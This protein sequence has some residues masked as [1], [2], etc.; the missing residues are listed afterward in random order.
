MKRVF[1]VVV[2]FGGMCLGGC[3]G[4]SADHG[5]SAGAG[6]EETASRYP[7]PSPSTSRRRDRSE[8]RAKGEEKTATQASP[9]QA[10]ND[11][12]LTTRPARVMDAKTALAF[13]ASDELEGRGIGSKGL[14]R[15]GD[16]VAEQFRRV[17]LTTAPG[18]K[19]FFQ[20]FEMTTAA[21]VGKGTAF[22]LEASGGSAE[23]GWAGGRAYDVKKDFIPLSFSAEKDFAGDLVFA[24][25]GISS[26]KFGYDDYAKLDV[27]GKVVLVL[28]FEP[29]TV[30]ESGADAKSRF[31]GDQWS[32]EAHLTT[33]AKVAREHGA[34]ALLL[35]TPPDVKGTEALL[36][37][38]GGAG[39]AKIPGVQIKQSVADELLKRG[40]G[41]D[42]KTLAEKIDQANG[43]ASF[44]LSGVSVKGKVAID[45][46]KA[47]VRNVVAVLPGVGPGANEYIVIGAHYDHLGYGGISSLSPTTRAIHNG[48]DDNASGTAALLQIAE[49]LSDGPRLPRSVIFAAFTGEEE[50]IIG[51]EHFVDHPPAPLSKIAAMLNLDMVGRLKDEVLYIGGTGTAPAFEGIIKQ[52]DE[53]SKLSWKDTGKGG[54]GPSDHMAFG[55]K[56]IPVMFFFT[57]LHADYH[58][59][60]DDADKVNYQ[61]L[62]EVIEFVTDIARRVAAMDRQEYVAKF[63]SQSMKMGTPSAGRVSL[64]VVPDYSNMGNGGGGG[65][66]KISGTIP[67]SPAAKAGLKEG[68]V[69]VQ[70]GETK[71]DNLYDLSDA[72]AK[73]KPG[74]KVHLKIKHGDNIVETDA[75]LVEKK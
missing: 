40:G 15:A 2:M 67:D 55:M 28:R 43:P 3:H 11:P 32:S 45:H 41:A 17:G 47:E 23:A 22:S 13:L 33:K 52:A 68:D 63:D 53:A 54:L 21:E 58:R 48:A 44:A 12:V 5:K 8:Y 10:L 18:M 26:E 57:G 1:V 7:H 69:I 73:G 74:Q 71:L 30:S 64:G 49:R 37:F 42:L 19:D 70:F 31:T 6:A 20:R 34:V 66:V 60:T 75:T 61:G 24:G 62:G 39:E 29:H 65:G 25:Y 4:H 16:F 46:Q 59:P 38:G 27:K 14:A 72:L 51:S 9:L 50:G 36:P 56:K 35:V